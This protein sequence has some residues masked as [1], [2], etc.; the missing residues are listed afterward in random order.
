MKKFLMGLLLFSFTVFVCIN[1]DAYAEEKKYESN[2]QT[3]FYGNYIYPDDEKKETKDN[4]GPSSRKFD[5][6][7][8]GGSHN[9]FS[10]KSYNRHPRESEDYVTAGKTILPR[11]G[12]FIDP[13]YSIIGIGLLLGM[14]GLIYKERKKEMK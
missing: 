14:F 11:T 1:S 13:L 2:G 12:D 10:K 5:D 7:I 4:V 3:S 6:Q 9:R 8:S